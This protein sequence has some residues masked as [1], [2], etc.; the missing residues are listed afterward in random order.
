MG[1]WGYFKNLLRLGF[2]RSQ[3]RDAIRD[4]GNTQ[5]PNTT[6]S[7]YL[8]QPNMT[9]TDAIRLVLLAVSVILKINHD[10][11]WI[12]NF[13]FCNHVFHNAFHHDTKR[14]TIKQCHSV[15]KLVQNWRQCCFWHYF[16]IKVKNGRFQLNNHL[17]IS[18]RSA[19]S[20]NIDRFVVFRFSSSL[21][22]PNN[23]VVP[24]CSL[25]NAYKSLCLSMIHPF[26][27]WK[28]RN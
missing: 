11:C 21:K 3:G 26:L 1:C 5:Q 27:I 20:L 25:K 16:N 17:K 7:I 4:S 9:R 18:C 28:K 24:Q 6:R 22:D 14:Y 2:C 23:D 13:F 12:F 15:A 10:A 19:R 8:Q